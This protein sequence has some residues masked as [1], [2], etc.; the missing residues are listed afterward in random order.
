MIVLNQN[1]VVMQCLQ[2][3]VTS[4]NIKKMS[5]IKL[6]LLFGILGS[7]IV[8]RLVTNCYCEKLFLSFVS[9]QSFLCFWCNKVIFFCT[10]VRYSVLFLFDVL[11]RE[12]NC[13]ESRTHNAIFMAM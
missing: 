7:V 11:H 2:F 8:A 3:W 6:N 4:V 12:L 5:K 1:T 13:C 10:D 9:F